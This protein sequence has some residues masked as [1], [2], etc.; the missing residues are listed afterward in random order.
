MS[1]TPANR[2]FDESYSRD[3]VPLYRYLRRLT[4]SS[5][6]AEDLLQ[7]VFLKLHLQLEAGAA[8]E[9]LRAWLFR[10]ATH[11]A[12][13][14]GKAAARSRAREQRYELSATV[15]DF[16]RHVEDRHDVRRAL[17]LLPARMRQILLLHAEGFS[18]RELAEITGIEPGYA[19]VLLQRARAEFKRIYEDQG[20]QKRDRSVG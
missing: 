1:G 16:Q 15:V 12:H 5:S 17:L 19:G 10:V 14:R 9:N 3:A 18:Y 6:A 2:S 13:D 4:G 20:G 11:L 8:I 7:E